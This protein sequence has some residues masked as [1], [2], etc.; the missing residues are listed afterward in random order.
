MALHACYTHLK[1]CFSCMFVKKIHKIGIVRSKWQAKMWFFSRAPH[2][3]IPP[4]V[5]G[6]FIELPSWNAIYIWS[7]GPFKY[8]VTPKEKGI[9]YFKNDRCGLF[10]HNISVA[11]GESRTLLKLVCA[12]TQI[13]WGDNCINRCL[14]SCTG[15]H[16]GFSVISA[17]SLHFTHRAER[18]G[19]LIF[20]YWFW[21]LIRIAPV[22]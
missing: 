13:N 15:F 16:H 20:R 6:L 1:S 21:W 22:P 9:F 10:P 4:F 11:L 19:V 3:P 5:T 7:T 8:Y 14:S 2:T 17:F 12:Y 18:E